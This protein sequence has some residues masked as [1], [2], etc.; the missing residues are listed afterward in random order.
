MSDPD[1]PDVSASDR[2]DKWL[3]RARFF[4]TRSLAAKAVSA[5]VRLNARRVE[6]PG[7][8]VRVGDVL[9]FSRDGAVFVVEIRALGARRGPAAE[10]RTLW[11]DRGSTPPPP[12]RGPP[13]DGRARREARALRRSD[14]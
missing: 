14:T 6:K 13:P 3:W 1:A 5:G 11:A 9:T 7:A 10:A 12:R 8:S 2:L 4:K